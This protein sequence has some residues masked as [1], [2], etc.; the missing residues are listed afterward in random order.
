VVLGCEILV[1]EIGYCPIC[2]AAGHGLEER[3]SIPKW[4]KKIFHS[5]ESSRL[6][7]PLH[8]SLQGL[9]EIPVDRARFETRTPPIHLNF[10]CPG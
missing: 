1:M 6:C 5:T 10:Y 9:K 8:L 3:I 4:R 7:A 2:I